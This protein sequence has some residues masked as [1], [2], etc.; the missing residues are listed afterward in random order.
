MAI[1]YPIGQPSIGLEEADLVLKALQKTQLTQGENVLEFE[2]Q[3]AGY[4]G[5]RFAVACT[6]GTSALHLALVAARVGPGDEVLVPDITYVAT[7]NAVRYTGATPVLVDVLHDTWNIDLE[8]AGRKLSQKTKAI[9]PVHLYGTPCNMN[10]VYRFTQFF[11]IKV[12]E[13]A[14]EA[15][16]GTFNGANCGTFGN[17]GIFSF[18]ANKVITTGEGGMVVTND[19]DLATA[20]RFYRGQAQTRRYFHEAVGFNYR[21]TDIQAAIGIAQLDKIK[22][23]L[24]KRRVV[25]TTYQRELR[26]VLTY[27]RVPGSAPWLFTG[28]SPLPYYMVAPKIEARGV[29]VRPMFVPMHRLPMYAQPDD[30]FPIASAICDYG[31]SLPTWP[32]LLVGDVKTIAAVATESIFD[33]RKKVTQ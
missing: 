32:G 9:I 15:L 25:V 5:S 31:I 17:M 12:I 8:D 16:G 24:A 26:D 6:S 27:P 28:L 13:D 30:K 21:M 19:E 1:K 14:A 33:F 11:N 22:D 2:R 10:E 3:F 23:F 7:A 20:L 4:I 29:E 18:Y